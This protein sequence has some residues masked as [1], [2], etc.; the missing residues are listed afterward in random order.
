MIRPG[1]LMDQKTGPVAFGDKYGL[2]VKLQKEKCRSRQ[3]AK[4]KTQKLER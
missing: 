4:G 1:I 2:Q 3:N